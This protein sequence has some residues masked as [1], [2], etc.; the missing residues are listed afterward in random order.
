M[1]QERTI[2]YV[3]G[4][5]GGGLYVPKISR[6]HFP[7]FISKMSISIKDISPWK[8]PISLDEMFWFM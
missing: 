4:M 7:R 1:L 6:F 2:V 8:V 3:W 5:G